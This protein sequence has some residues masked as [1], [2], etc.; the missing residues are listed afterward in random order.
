MPTVCA[1]V[2]QPTVAFTVTFILT[3]LILSRVGAT[4]VGVLDWILDLLTTY[5]S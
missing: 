4:I 1:D 2:H 5:K 3:L